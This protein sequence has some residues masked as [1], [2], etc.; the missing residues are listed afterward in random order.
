[1]CIGAWGPHTPTPGRQA[2]PR[3]STLPLTS[4]M[5]GGN[6]TWQGPRVHLKRRRSRTVCGPVLLLPIPP[7][8][9]GL[10]RVLI[11][12]YESPPG[13]LECPR[14]PSPPTNPDLQLTRTTPRKPPA[15]MM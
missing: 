13:A 11:V 7:V 3:L 2:L 14:N 9:P 15:N 12:G 5:G 10:A 4:E 6:A 8:G 1:M